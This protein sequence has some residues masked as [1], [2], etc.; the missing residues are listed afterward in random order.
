MKAIKINEAFS[1]ESDPIKDMAIGVKPR[2][3][4]SLFC[5]EF[6]KEFGLF[7][8]PDECGNDYECINTEIYR[9]GDESFEDLKN[10]VVKLLVSTKHELLMAMNDAAANKIVKGAKWGWFYYDGGTP[11][12]LK[13]AYELKD[14]F[15]QI[16]KVSSIDDKTLDKAVIRFE[17]YLK[18]I[19]KMKEIHG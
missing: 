12:Y 6:H 16:F 7:A 14:V 8:Y 9:L 3:V 15:K 11:K 1:E 18:T 19:K 4:L 2:D 17:G 5:E 13:G 10:P